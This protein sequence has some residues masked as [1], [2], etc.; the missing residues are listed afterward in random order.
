MVAKCVIRELDQSL[1]VFNLSHIA[2]LE[3]GSACAIDAVASVNLIGCFLATL[4][5]EI[6]ENN[7]AATRS[8][9]VSQSAAETTCGASYN[10]NRTCNTHSI[11]TIKKKQSRVKQSKVK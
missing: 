3:N 6:T 2:L 5:V 1:E 11:R 10:S 4:G 9:A 8:E 7:L